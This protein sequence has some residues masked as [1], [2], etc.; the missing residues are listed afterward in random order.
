MNRIKQ[1][2]AEIKQQE[3]EL[4]ETRKVIDTYQR[5]IKE[6]EGDLKD[7]KKEGDDMQKYEV[8]YQKEKEINDFC[9]NFDDEKANYEKQI[10]DSQK[11]IQNLLMHMAKV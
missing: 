10:S 7:K 3:K 6:I 1:D 9:G 4:T 8:L 2:N 5:N 11:L